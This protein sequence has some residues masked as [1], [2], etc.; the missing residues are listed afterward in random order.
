MAARDS[1]QTR[2]PN[3]YVRQK[4]ATRQVS[5]RLAERVCLHLHDK[6]LSLVRLIDTVLRR[7]LAADG[8]DLQAVHADEFLHT[9]TY[10]D[11][12]TREQRTMDLTYRDHWNNAYGADLNGD[13][14]YCE[15]SPRHLE[16]AGGATSIQW[17]TATRRKPSCP[18]NGQRVPFTAFDP[19]VPPEE[20][21]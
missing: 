10:E 7:E 4:H 5:I 9:I 18:L 21:S 15:C 3:A 16:P 13:P 17:H 6:G 2:F 11:E 1:I 12:V 8:V 14:V 19:S 20:P